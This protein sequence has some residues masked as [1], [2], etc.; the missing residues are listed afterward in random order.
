MEEEGEDEMGWN[1]AVAF[2]MDESD[3]DGGSLQ[4]GKKGAKNKN[5]QAN[6][7]EMDEPMDD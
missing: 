6:F 1:D 5:K 7:D 3:D 4:K 2:E